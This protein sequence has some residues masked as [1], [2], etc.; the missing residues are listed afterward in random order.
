[1]I[2]QLLTVL[3]FMLKAEEV[4]SSKCVRSLPVPGLC[5]MALIFIVLYFLTVPGT[6]LVEKWVCGYAVSSTWF[7]FGYVLGLV[8][9]SYFVSSLLVE[10]FPVLFT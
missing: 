7:P 5:I 2:Y 4:P 10:G 1:M 3:R 9:F 6:L 8:F